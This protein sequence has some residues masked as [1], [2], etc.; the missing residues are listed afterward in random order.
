[1]NCP[2]VSIYVFRNED[3]PFSISETLVAFASG[4]FEVGGP[5]ILNFVMTKLND[6]LRSKHLDKEV[7]MYLDNPGFRHVRMKLFPNE[8]ISD[9]TSDIYIFALGLIGEYSRV[10]NISDRMAFEFEAMTQNMQKW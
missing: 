2:A 3:S 8:W 6:N 9:R 4:I 10:E 5:D 7:E 1:M